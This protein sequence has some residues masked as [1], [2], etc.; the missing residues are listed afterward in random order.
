M[1]TNQDK[2]GALA[3]K[4]EAAFCVFMA[5]AAY[6]WRENPA[7]AYPGIFYLLLAL[8]GINL[9][10]GFLLRRWPC[11]Q[12]IAAAFIAANCATITAVLAHS[13]GAQSNLWVLYLLPI[14]TVC[15]LLGAREVLWI[16]AGA[17][18]FNAAFLAF[19][20]GFWSAQSTFELL[21]KSGVFVFS[22]AITWKISERDRRS[23]TRLQ[24]DRMELKN[25]EE[26]LQMQND[27]LE[28]S[29]K[30]AEVG[31][32]S[33]GITHDLNNT[34]MVILGFIDIIRRSDS[35]AT[36]LKEDVD[37][38]ERSAKLG[39]N[40]LFDFRAA[41]KREKLVLAPCDLHGTIHS[42][43]DI[44]KERVKQHAVEVQ[45]QLDENLPMI[46]ANRTH[47]QRLFLNIV[48]NAIRAMKE[49][50]VL[51]IKTEALAGPRQGLG[52]I[53]VS[54]EDSG[55]G[56]PDEILA[57]MFKP[58]STTMKAEGGTGLGLYISSEIAK[59]HNGRLHAE[60]KKEGGARLVLF[61]PACPATSPAEKEARHAR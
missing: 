3:G 45:L 22:A 60:N 35:L 14:Y 18:G 38:I 29:E 13:G 34:F 48:S 50:G 37:H 55:P 11:K 16:T 59:Q 4:Y 25:L 23:R 46:P 2:D 8:M 51:R 5:A 43:L 44:L 32:L 31:L 47:L 53:R 9:A 61:L 21:L 41:A 12:W 52:Q 39:K 49:G 10:A 7:I 58:F 57:R 6:L 17:I 20:A 24:A 36:D 30:L 26:L 15:L 56:I 33:S 28:S 42:I 40:I 19:E 27:K 1:E 54:V